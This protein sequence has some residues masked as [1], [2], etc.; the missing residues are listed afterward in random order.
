METHSEPK[1]AEVLQSAADVPGPSKEKAPVI[2]IDGPAGTGKSTL[3]PRLC[4]H[5]AWHYI[6]SGAMYRAVALYAR[7]RGISW[8]DE[9]ALVCLCNQLVFEFCIRGGRPVVRVNRRDVTPM[10]RT[11]TLG[12]GASRVGTLKGVREVL[13]RKQRELGRLGGI[14]M[15]GR[16]IGTVVFPDADIKFFLDATPE[17]RAQRRQLELQGRGEHVSLAAVTAEMRQ[18]DHEDRTREVSPLRVPEGAYCIDTTNLSID[19]VFTLMVDKIKLFG[20]SSRMGNSQ[21]RERCL[22]ST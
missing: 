12:E 17:V 2:A 1:S 11:Q 8:T 10:I 20:V 3:A 6:D 15:D 13:V 19:E 21:R 5:F 16:D 14:V 4:E 9:A 7:Q 18:R 22:K